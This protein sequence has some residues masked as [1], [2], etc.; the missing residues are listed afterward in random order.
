MKVIFALLLAAVNS[1]G[2]K[3]DY[4]SNGADWP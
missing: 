3:Y 2:V 1:A 4:S